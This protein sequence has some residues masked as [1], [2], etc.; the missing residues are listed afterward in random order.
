MYKL[1]S[2]SFLVTF[3]SIFTY[4]Y[5]YIYMYTYLYIYIYIYIY[6]HIYIYILNYIYIY[7]YIYTYTHIY[8]YIYMCI[9]ILYIYIY[10]LYIYIYIQ[11]VHIKTHKYR[12]WVTARNPVVPRYWWLDSSR[13]SSRWQ[14]P[15]FRSARC[16]KTCQLADQ[17]VLET[18]MDFLNIHIDHV[19]HQT[20]CSLPILHT[21]IYPCLKL[22]AS[23]HWIYFFGFMFEACISI[24]YPLV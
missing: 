16:T 20:S 23:T 18:K 5:I 13:D 8:V 12:T 22:V 3:I 4:I 7:I 11:F 14:L 19:Y 2:R 6:I 9:F 15:S 1:F 21:S 24:P 17:G 10:I